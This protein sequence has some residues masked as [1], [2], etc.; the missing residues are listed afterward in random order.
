MG[1]LFIFTTEI[2]TVV[3]GLSNKHINQLR[4]EIDQGNHTKHKMNT[5]QMIACI[6]HEV[7]V[8]KYVQ[9]NKNKHKRKVHHGFDC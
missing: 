3:I 1:Q 8:A 9:N 4:I 5:Y 7:I 2:N 6:G